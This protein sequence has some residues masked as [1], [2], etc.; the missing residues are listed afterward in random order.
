MKRLVVALVIGAML[1]IAAPAHAADNAVCAYTGL[2]T[3]KPGLP[4]VTGASSKVAY[5]SHG[6]TGT[7]DC[8]GSLKGHQITG[9]GT[10]TNSGYIVGNCAQTT[11]AGRYV[12]RIPTDGGTKRVSGRYTFQTVG[13]VGTFSG[14]A[15]SGVFNFVAETGDCVTTPV[16]R[17]TTR[18]QGSLSY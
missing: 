12:L 14:S 10:F 17:V 3:L 8:R 9:V 5:S 7:M 4:V 11:G 13:A 6:A 15:Y 1:V 2:L 18:A 16:T